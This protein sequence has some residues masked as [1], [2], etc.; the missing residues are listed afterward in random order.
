MK[1][2]FIHVFYIAVHLISL[3]LSFEFKAVDVV[4]DQ[5]FVSDLTSYTINAYR[6]SNELL[7]FTPWDL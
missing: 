3:S 6:Y 7:D 1:P 5:P 2:S 4:L